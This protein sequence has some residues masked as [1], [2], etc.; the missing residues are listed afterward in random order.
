MSY[1]L[2]NNV[3]LAKFPGPLPSTFDKVDVVNNASIKTGVSLNLVDQELVD[4]E[5]ETLIKNEMEAVQVSGYLA[6][7]VPLALLINNKDNEP[8]PVL[9][10]STLNSYILPNASN[11]DELGT[12]VSQPYYLKGP[13][14][15]H[16]RW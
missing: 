7:T 13:T 4:Q 11:V 1:R 14:A 6:T 2:V 12:P 15:W 8:D 10:N 16:S 9:I 3:D 5:R